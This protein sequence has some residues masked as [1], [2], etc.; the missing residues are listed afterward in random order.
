MLNKPDLQKLL[1]SSR[2]APIPGLRGDLNVVPVSENGS[3]YLYFHDPMG[4]ATPD[5]ALD[6]HAETVLSLLDGRRT[7]EGFKPYLGDGISTDEVLNYVRFLDENRLLYSNY[8]KKYSEELELQY[9]SGKTHPSNTAGISYPSDPG[10]LRTYLQQMF[11]RYSDPAPGPAPERIRALYAPHIDPRVGI[12]SYVKAFYPLR[13]LQPKKVV[14]LA[15]SHYAGLHPDTYDNRPF[16][17]TRKDFKLPLGTVRTDQDSIDRLLRNKEQLGLTDHDRAHRVEHS[18]ELHLLFLNY[19]W[20]HNFEIVPI[21]VQGFDELYFMKNSHLS[22]Q[23]DH[24]GSALKH[25]FGEN[26]DTLFLI[27]GDLAHIGKKFGDSQPASELF[28]DIRSFD[29]AFLHHAANGSCSDLLELMKRDYDPYRICG[30]P[31]LYTFLRAIPELK[32][33][34][35]SYDL[36]DE[37]ERES[38]VSFGTVLYTD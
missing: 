35:L 10:E 36:W 33:R 15:T 19:L 23:I 37:S 3:S 20:D 34:Q 11:Q 32:G 12:E 4:Y 30:F 8:F 18:I 25:L 31:P 6:S 13:G 28:N 27:S 9:E 29:A 1:F 7:V 26:E 22:K 24:M 21:L 17:T 5:F 14:I 2:T 38:A 16:I